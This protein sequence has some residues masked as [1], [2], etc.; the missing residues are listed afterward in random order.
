MTSINTSRITA[1]ELAMTVN[2]PATVIGAMFFRLLEEAGYTA[3]DIRKVARTL[4]TY[5]DDGTG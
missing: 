4:Y 2:E 1:F 3:E 5:V